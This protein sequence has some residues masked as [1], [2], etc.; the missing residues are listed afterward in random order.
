MGSTTPTTPTPE[1]V[2][3]WPEAYAIVTGYIPEKQPKGVHPKCRPLLVT[4]VLRSKQTGIIHL[5]VAYGTSQIRFP[6]RATSDLIIQ[7]IS[8]MDACGLQTPT[9]FV[10]NPSEQYIMPWDE[11]HFAPW[12][13]TGTPRRGRLTDELQRE[14]AWLMA[15]CLRS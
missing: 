14:Y 15:A 12:G 8:D 7:N 1:W 2:K 10:I 11:Y 9:R 3:R 4:Q 6:E 13:A 5:R